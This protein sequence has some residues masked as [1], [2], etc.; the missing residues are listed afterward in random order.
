VFG[1][2]PSPQPVCASSGACSRVVTLLWRPLADSTME[3]YRCAASRKNFYG[4]LR[5]ADR[6][7]GRSPKEALEWNRDSRRTIPHTGALPLATTYYASRR[8][9]DGHRGSRTRSPQR[10]G[11][12][13]LGAGTCSLR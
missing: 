1:N 13:G 12:I 7:L 6:A 5:L 10:V 3:A 4:T 2:L 11:V 9:L 8:A